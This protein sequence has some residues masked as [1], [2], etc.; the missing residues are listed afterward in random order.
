VDAAA[1]AITVGIV[2][3]SLMKAGIA[4]VVGSARFRWQAGATLLAM[5]AAGTGALFLF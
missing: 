5:A 2:A 4:V 1:R 3:N